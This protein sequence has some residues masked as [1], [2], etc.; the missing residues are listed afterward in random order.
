MINSYISSESDLKSL[1]K[2]IDD[3]KIVALDTE[4]IRRNTY[5]PILSLIQVAVD[6]QI[7]VVDCLCGLDI[8]CM[9]KI[10]NDDKIIKILHSSR[11]DLEI[12]YKESGA[13]PK[14]IHDT[15]ILANFCG[16]D[17][18]ASYANLVKRF[19]NIDLD[20][21]MQNSNW[22]RRPLNPRQIEYAKIDVLYLE[23]IYFNLLKI[24]KKKGLLDSYHQDV[25]LLSNSLLNSSAD[26]MFKSFTKSRMKNF[27]KHK[28]PMQKVLDLLILRDELAQKINIPRRHLI[29]DENLELAIL[30]GEIKCVLDKGSKKSFEKILKKSNYDL[31]LEEKSCKID[32]DNDNFDFARKE[33]GDIAK[34]LDLKDQFILS[35]ANLKSIF[36]HD[37]DVE[38][39]TSWRRSIIDELKNKIDDEKQIDC[40]KLENE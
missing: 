36:S 37:K 35:C 6:G 21:K 38:N 3:C 27:R 18:N 33:L 8:S 10:I 40:S 26:S 31:D 23:R 28:V 24:V 22:L 39:M 11:Q 5:F 4:F 15:Q 9:L 14:N 7:Y 25:A 17:F 32:L 20:K 12:F 13:L 34:K 2:K 19:F 16:F 29:S 30:A 1:C